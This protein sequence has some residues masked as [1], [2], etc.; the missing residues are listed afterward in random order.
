MFQSRAAYGSFWK[1]TSIINLGHA[2]KARTSSILKWERQNIR[3]LQITGNQS[4]DNLKNLPVVALCQLEKAI[5][6]LIY[7]LSFN[8]LTFFLLTFYLTIIFFL[9]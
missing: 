7:L 4:I 8:L 2:R 9:S 6:L 1:I 5:L 3:L